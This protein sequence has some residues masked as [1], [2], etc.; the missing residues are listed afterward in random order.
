MKRRPGFTLLELLIVIAIV[1]ILVAIGTASY[2]SAQ[3]RSRDTRRQSDMKA[4]QSAFEQFRSE[5][6]AYP[7]SCTIDAAFLP[8]GIPV[9]PRGQNYSQVCNP[10]AYCFCAAMEIDASGN[11]SSNC[12]G[13]PVSEKFFC[14]RNLQ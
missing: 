2:A 3:R 7:S 10:S 5:T 4:I 8:G 6:G 9:D 14:V 12:G 11:A 13:S 1:G